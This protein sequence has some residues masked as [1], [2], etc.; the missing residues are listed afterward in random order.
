MN[1]DEIAIATVSWAR[2]A[3]EEKILKASLSQLAL[4]NVPVFITDG[5]SPE[6]FVTFLQSLP[7][8]TVLIEKDKGLFAQ[9]K[10]SLAAAISAANPFIFYTEPDKENFFREGLP[11]VLET[12]TAPNDLGVLLASRSAKGFASFPAFQ[13]MTETTINNCCT[14]LMGIEA[15]YCY[16]PFLLNKQLVTLLEEIK[17]DIG[18]GWRPFVFNRAHRLGYT[19]KAFE[20]NF[21]CPEG[22]RNDDAAE[23]IYRMKQ[24]EQNMRGLVLATAS[25]Q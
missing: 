12:A 22:Q 13:Q 15:D 3:E 6:G 8:F 16:G 17:E 14:E 9:V 19:V 4:L 25:K 21:L 5:G 18:W 11:K 2:N 1:K 10:S 24:L 20:D 7:H 23:R